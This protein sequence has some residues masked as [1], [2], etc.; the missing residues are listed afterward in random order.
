[1]KKLLLAT[2]ALGLFAA[3]SAHAAAPTVTIGGYADFQVGSANQENDYDDADNEING[4]GVTGTNDTAAGVFSR[5]TH[6]AQEAEIRVNV[7]GKTDAGL[8]Y[9]AY[10][11]LNA[12][13]NADA[14]VNNYNSTTDNSRNVERSYIYVEGGFGR[15]EAGPTTDAGNALRVNA[16]TL[17]RATG[18]VSGD[19]YRYIDF[20]GEPDANT[21]HGTVGDT[22]VVIPELPTAGLPSE[23]ASRT[24]AAR[25]TAN[26]VSY[27]SPRIS[28]LQLGVSYTPDQAERGTTKGF[29][30][31]QDSNNFESVW[32]L[33]LNY[34]NEF[35]GVGVEASATAE[36]GDSEISSANDDLEAYALGLNVDYA[37][38]TV[39]GS[40]AEADEFGRAS[41]NNESYQYWTAGVAYEFGP[42]AA[43]ATYL[44]SAVENGDASSV[45][46]DFQNVVV[47]ADYQLAPGLVPYVEVSFFE[48]DDNTTSNTDNE[49]TVFLV[50]TE[51]SF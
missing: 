15:V 45:D 48:T 47:G 10:I 4:A 2:S 32:N 51:L 25:A 17:A 12:N 26:K 3:A 43:S 37:G 21:S 1:M 49:G 20:D 7:D 9:G 30:G 23:V 11:E 27:Y 22:F 50:G 31:E 38:F 46:K 40:W 14:N 36:Y 44:E 34:Q 42:F 16:G 19:F 6:T 41:A 8:G 29:S 24:H 33:G 5:D 13:V 28:G 35:Q 18:G 39:G